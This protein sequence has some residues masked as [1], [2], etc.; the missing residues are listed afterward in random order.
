MVFLCVEDGSPVI[1][2][3]VLS[4]CVLKVVQIGQYNLRGHQKLRISV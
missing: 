1:F 4:S 2:P 3:E